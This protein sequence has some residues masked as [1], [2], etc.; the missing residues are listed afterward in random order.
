MAKGD[1]MKVRLLAMGL[2]LSCSVA[3]GQTQT[4]SR[5]Q[6]G[7]Q[8]QG[9]GATPTTGQSAPTPP[10]AAPAAATPPR[11]TVVEEIVARVNNEIIT[12]VDLERAKLASVD[13]AKQDCSSPTKTCTPEELRKE[14]SDM[15]RDALRNLIDEKLLVQRGKDMSLSVETDVIRQL[16]QIR[17]EHKLA[18]L[19]D[20]EKAVTAEGENYDD[21]KNNLRNHLIINEVINREVYA[22][23]GNTVDH[24]QMQKYYDEHKEE[25]QSPEIVYLREILVSTDQKD[26]S[27]IPA[28]EKK[29]NALRERVLNGED[30]GELAKHFSDGSTGKQGGE[31]GKFERGMLAKSIEEQVFKLNRKEMTPVIH[32][33]NGFMIIQ[34][35]ERFEAGVQPLDKVQNQIIGRIASKQAEPKLR[36]YL[37]TLRKDSFVEVH[38]GYTDTAGVAGESITEI[39]TAAMDPTTTKAPP[40]PKKHKR[41]LLF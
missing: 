28:L 17:M 8:T 3:I 19:E 12:T 30:F 29:A 37:N 27:E 13:D 21:F 18:T 38:A 2:A 36:E 31:L 1:F 9:R 34:V 22:R 5:T 23:I 4:Q 15:Q 41:F 14:I 11:G 25:F 6:K 33:Q 26:P 40:K 32:A 7:T 20:L 35:V 10:P 39:N 16:D 24:A